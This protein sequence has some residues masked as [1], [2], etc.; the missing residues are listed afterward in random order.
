MGEKEG[1][2]VKYQGGPLALWVV[3]V[4]RGLWLIIPEPL[5]RSYTI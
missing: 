1:L 3:V 5:E 4:N 2:W